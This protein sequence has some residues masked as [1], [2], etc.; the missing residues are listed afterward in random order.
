MVHRFGIAYFAMPASP[1]G[2]FHRL[3]FGPSL[4][5]GDARIVPMAPL[6]IKLGCSANNS[7]IMKIY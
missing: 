6:I 1:R 2:Q 4:R 5:F 3:P 7:M